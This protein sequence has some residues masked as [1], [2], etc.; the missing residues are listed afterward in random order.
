MNAVI[1]NI[2]VKAKYR[3]EELQKP[4]VLFRCSYVPDMTD[5]GVRRLVTEKQLGAATTLY[6]HRSAPALEPPI[7]VAPPASAG[8]DVLADL[9]VEDEPDAASAEP[10]VVHVTYVGRRRAG[11]FVV[12]TREQADRRLFT[13]DQAVAL[14]AKQCMLAGA[15]VDLVWETKNDEAWIISIERVRPAAVETRRTRDP[16]VRPPRRSASAS[17]RAQWRPARGAGPGD[18]R[19]PGAPAPCRLAVAG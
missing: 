13:D 2:G 19:V 6:P 18:R 4:F 14:E 7:D 16:P 17:R 9:P 5:P 1:R 15:P 12:K 8:D 10:T 11:G 3:L